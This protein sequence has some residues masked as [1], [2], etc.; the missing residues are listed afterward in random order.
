MLCVACCV[1]SV[2]SIKAETDN[3]VPNTVNVVGGYVFEKYGTI[4]NLLSRLNADPENIYTIYSLD[5]LT[6]LTTGLVETKQQVKL[7]NVFVYDVVVIGDLNSDGEADIA[8]IIKL[9]RHIIGIDQIYDQTLIKAGDVNNDGD[10]DIGDII[11][12]SRYILKEVE[13]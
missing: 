9:S 3:I 11:K 7:N 1:D 2:I 13:L 10:V 6:N 4:S 5:G 12:I 8:D